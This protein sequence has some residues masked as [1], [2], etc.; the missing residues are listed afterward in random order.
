MISLLLV[1]VNSL[2][3]NTYG[4]STD[5]I[6][7]YAEDLD[8]GVIAMRKGNSAFIS[9]RFL[10]TDD[11]SIS[12]NV[13][14]S[15]VEYIENPENHELIKNVTETVKLNENPIDKVTYFID[16]TFDKTKGFEYFVGS[17]IN[18]VEV[19]NSSYSYIQPNTQ[20]I[21]CIKIP[22]RP[23]T[24]FRTVWV[25]DLNG[26]GKFDFVL[27]RDAEE[28]QRIEAYLSNGTFLWEVNLG[29]NSNNKNNIRPGP[30]TVNV[31]HWDGVNV[32]DL[33]GDGKAE[34]YFRIANNVTFGDGQVFTHENDV[35]QW[36][37]SVDGL[38]GKLKHKARIPDTFIQ[39]GSMGSQMGVGFLDGVK[40]SLVSVMK[41]RDSK[42]VF[43]MIIAAY[44]FNSENEF[45]LDWSWSPELE[46]NC[47]GCSDGHHFR[48]ADVDGDGKEEILEVGFTLNG[49]GTLRYD[50]YNEG[51]KHG[52]RFYV[53]KFNK[54]DKT[55]KGYGVQQDHNEFLLEYVYDADKGKVIWKHFNKE[56][57]TV[58]VGRGNIGDFDPEYPGLE[59][60]SFSGLFTGSTNIN[61]TEV[62]NASALPSKSLWPSNNVYWDSDLT[63]ACFHE[64]FLNKWNY[65]TNVADR[66]YTAYSDYNKKY[67]E[68]PSRDDTYPMFH[69]DILGDWREEFIMS[70]Q[71]YS[72]IIIFST[73]TETDLRLTTLSQD[74]GMRASM[75]LNGYKQSHMP[76]N[77]LGHETDLNE[78][79]KSLKSY[80]S[81]RG[82]SSGKKKL[83][84]GAIAA[85]VIVVILVVV[86][87]AVG[88]FIF[89]RKRSS[90][91]NTFRLSAV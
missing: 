58:D 4:Y 9:W 35:D 40:P 19:E 13:Y 75:T 24:R 11:D 74:P 37:A 36:I 25:G 86:A 67:G 34:V 82:E 56:N 7:R 15:S 65:K 43:H 51:V 52:D 28:E 41:N 47:K 88:I 17:I 80:A 18:N 81:L 78:H 42:N 73:T 66:L 91:D 8:R 50:L 76:Y 69:G 89:L 60:Y 62:K 5:K 1:L 55:M 22:I 64:G 33:D 21:P 49:D 29:H 79:R 20:D 48:I 12:F 71:N 54:G 70:N 85:I 63:P 90:G 23:G 44:S 30:T 6:S 39:H 46:E 84:G 87:V 68:Y 77:F 10:I 83:S 32:Y 3:G 27:A 38:T 57:V 72:E 61:L 59:V 14:R 53:T 2:K 16:N 31:G 45:V 26:D